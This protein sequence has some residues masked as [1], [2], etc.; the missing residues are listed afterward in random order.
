M[1]FLLLTLLKVDQLPEV[2]VL[3]I[4]FENI[5]VLS[6][7]VIVLHNVN[8]LVLGNE[9]LVVVDA[10]LFDV[11]VGLS[12]EEPGLLTVVFLC[13]VHE[14]EKEDVIRFGPVVHLELD[15]MCIV[16]GLNSNVVVL[17]LLGITTLN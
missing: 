8:V 16:L 7:Q 4:L 5:I 3:N 2:H 6:K 9:T 15:I 11:I 1:V 13:L 10:Q 12:D 17:V 14:R